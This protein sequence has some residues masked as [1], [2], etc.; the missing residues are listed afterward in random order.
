MLVLQL[1]HLPCGHTASVLINK[2]TTM[3]PRSP[4]RI[5][6]WLSDFRHVKLISYRTDTTA[7][8]DTRSD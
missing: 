2:I 8:S 1:C 6:P 7:E 4:L 5:E 3:D